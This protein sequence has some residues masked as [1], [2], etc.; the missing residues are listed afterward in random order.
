VLF[1]R[2]ETASNSRNHSSNASK[3]GCDSAYCWVLKANVS[4]LSTIYQLFPLMRAWGIVEESYLQLLMHYKEL[5][6][7]SRRQKSEYLI[8]YVIYKIN[9][10]HFCISRTF[11]HVHFIPHFLLAT[12]IDWRRPFEKKRRLI[13]IKRSNKS[14]IQNIDYIKRVLLSVLMD[15]D[16]D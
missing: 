11:W 7:D 2:S 8:Y 12:H 14:F 6:P 4:V 9:I 13:N 1:W 16:H 15:R 10:F 3:F 5:S